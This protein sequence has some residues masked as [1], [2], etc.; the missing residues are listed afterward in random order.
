MI[1]LEHLNK[2]YN[3]G[4]N[5]EIHVINDTTLTLPDTGLVCILGESGSGKTTLMNTVSGLDDFESGTIE[6]DGQVVKKYGDEVQEKVRNQQF[7]YIFQNYYLLLNRSVDYNLRLALSMYDLPEQVKDQR[8]E[9]V[10]KSVG[11]WRYKKK[12]VGQLSGGQ[13]QRVAIAR[14][15]AKAP[16][17][18]FADE[19]TGNLDEANTM[20][21]MGILKKISK[22]CL[23]LLVTHEQR[24]AEF[25]ADKI[26]WIGEGTIRKMADNQSRDSYEYID[27]NNLYLK[28]FKESALK[29]RKVE[30]EIY[31]EDKDKK[32]G[33]EITLKLV[34]DNG[35]YYLA[36]DTERQVEFLTAASE[37]K[38]VDSKRPVAKKQ[39]IDQIS[40]DLQP[41]S[42]GS[43][44]KITFQDIRKIAAG[45]IRSM[46]K[47]K[48]FLYL[49]FIVVSL[50]FVFSMAN[51]MSELFVDEG[52]LVS[53]DSHY[54]TV[55]ADPESKLFNLTYEK[56]FPLLVEQLEK[57]GITAYNYAAPALTLKYQGFRQ[58]E[59]MEVTLPALSVTDEK[60]LKK[61]EIVSGN[62]PGNDLEIVLDVLVIRKLQD[63]YTEMK[64]LITDD[65]Q[66]IGLELVSDKGYHLKITGIC[67]TGEPDL[68]GTANLIV[69]LSNSLVTFLGED[70]AAAYGEQQ[71]LSITDDNEVEVLV[72]QK[73][74]KIAYQNYLKNNYGE[75]E[76]QHSRI[77]RRKGY[78]RSEM[79]DHDIRHLDREIQ[80]ISEGLEELEEEYGMTYEEYREK[81][82][83]D[84]AYL[85][86]SYTGSLFGTVEY[87]VA[88]CFQ[89]DP[90]VD[91][92]IAEEGFPMIS[93]AMMNVYKKFY[94][95]DENKNLASLRSKIEQVI[96]KHTSLEKGAVI[97]S[98]KAEKVVEEYR[99][100]NKE[101]ADSAILIAVTIVIISMVILYFI[102][103]A[104]VIDRIG[105]LGVYRMLGVSKASIYGMFA[106]EN[107]LITL[108]TSVP[109][110]L[111]S[112]LVFYGMSLL[113]VTESSF[114]FSPAALAGMILF[115][116]LMNLVIGILP[117]RKLMK[118]P[119][120]QLAAKYDV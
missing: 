68:Y 117:V 107:I 120:A 115:I 11:M 21:T 35:K 114:R 62:S 75:L 47:R 64:N 98:N 57:E 16:K 22:N 112:A 36:A 52:S 20:N 67:D 111:L 17:V 97:V 81:M 69:M 56:E 46:G 30:V 66:L 42:N 15:L 7:G 29:N 10:L 65:S 54:D 90:G 72:P 25:F 118:L 39:E 80:E 59:G 4:K 27:D 78:D 18:I 50:L 82:D 55:E 14:A 116:F 104:N 89:E 34:Y 49:T 113:P 31:E 83:S 37:K 12:N 105:D 2:Y 108:R 70:C 73:N 6:I 96:A 71:Q 53:T 40:Y 5:N 61:D 8:I 86:Y 58:V 23:V 48:R 88:G 110:I 43:K 41:L 91:Y 77:E 19:P 63:E 100:K 3:K 51:L 94:V 1:K 87:K 24:I 28:E 76:H 60:Y 93:Q 9:Y 79:S 26:I 45:N 33:E 38:V 103:K 99:D 13:Q 109:A 102:M 101:K 95:Y 92:I 32:E 74:L 84:T 119:P 85:D 106:Y 44:P